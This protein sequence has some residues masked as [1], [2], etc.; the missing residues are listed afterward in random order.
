MGTEDSDVIDVKLTRE[1]F[2][3]LILKT[4]KGTLDYVD[5]AMMRASLDVN[6]IDQVVSWK[7]CNLMKSC[8]ISVASWWLN[9]NSFSARTSDREIRQ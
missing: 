9:Q 2:N 7:I 1:K 3:E 8:T 4:V 5:K 6:D